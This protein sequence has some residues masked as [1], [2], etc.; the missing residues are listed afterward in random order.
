MTAAAPALRCRICEHVEPRP[1]DNACSRC[2]GPTDVAYDLAALA[3]LLTPARIAAGPEAM[4]RYRDLLPAEIGDATSRVGWT[5]LLHARVL[6]RALDIELRLKVE[7]LNPTGS[8]KDRTAALA[9]AAATSAG[10]ETVCCASDGPLGNAVAAEA[11]AHGFE[12]IVL[13]PASEAHVHWPARALGARVI[14]I[15]G[16]LEQCQRLAARLATLFPWGFVGGNLRPYAAEGTKTIAFEIA[17]QLGWQLPDVVVSAVASGTLFAKI[18]QG[19]H[20][21]REVGLARGASP[22]L[23]G[24]QSSRCAPVAAAYSEG[25]SHA[26]G[27]EVYGDLAIGAARTSGGAVLAVE[28]RLVGGYRQLVEAATGGRVDESAGIALGAAVQ[29]V[30]SGAIRSGDT[31]VL[32]VGGS[33]LDDGGAEPRRAIPPQLGRVLEELGAS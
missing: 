1:R 5:P 2:D 9:A 22:R 4:W 6:S 16:S 31:V 29:G 30:R 21:L 15:D 26:V 14:E 12:A 27:D 13:A 3:Q 18:A 33:A 23:I 17:E 19:F 32:V 10:Y 28:E 8:Y 20:E 24:A 7:T 11:R 25:L